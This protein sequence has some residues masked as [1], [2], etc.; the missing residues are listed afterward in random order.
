MAGIAGKNIVVI[1]GSRG[2]G[3]RIAETGAQQGARVLAVARHEAALR[4]VAREVPGIEVLALDASRRGAPLKV[5]GT[6]VPEILVLSGGAIPVT[7]PLHEQSWREFAVNWESD[8]RIAFY[9][10]KAALSR[11]LPAGSLVILIGSR[12]AFGGSPLTGGYAGSKRTQM[13]I[14]SYSQKES[15]RLGL[16]LRFVTLAPGIIPDSAFGRLAVSA[17]SK[18]L[19]MPA[20]EF[21]RGMAA[22]PT[23]SDVAKAL[24]ELFANSYDSS[25]KMYIV[26]GEGLETASICKW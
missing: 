5:F 23:T 18:Y 13:L 14:A 21:V 16:G 22:P 3:R 17:Y 4:D 2:V 8:V 12:A 9:F 24:V 7:A 19:A 11:P 10:C 26:T 25:G 20:S 6:L 1:G 15:D